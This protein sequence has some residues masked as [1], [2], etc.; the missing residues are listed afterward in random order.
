MVKQLSQLPFQKTVLL[1]STGLT[2]PPDQIEYWNSLIKLAN[3]GGVTFYGLDVF[4][5]GVCQD[6]PDCA[7]GSVVSTPSSASVG[8]TQGVAAMSQGQSTVGLPGRGQFAPGG[9]STAG[10]SPAEQLMQS[11]KQTDF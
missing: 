9:S 1:M 7:V 6:Q 4:G 3:K 11:M 5:L 10:P 2:R 8:M